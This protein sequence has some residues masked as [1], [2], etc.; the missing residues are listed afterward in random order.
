M[1]TDTTL[2][3]PQ[4]VEI[5]ITREKNCMVVSGAVSSPPAYKR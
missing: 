2:A 3:L 5:R 4:A 1:G